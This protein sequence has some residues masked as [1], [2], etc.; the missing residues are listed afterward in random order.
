MLKVDSEKKLR[1]GEI[2]ITP[3][4]LNKEFG[5]KH[6]AHDTAEDPQRKLGPGI[7]SRR[8]NLILM[9]RGSDHRFVFEMAK[10]QELLIGRYDPSSQTSPQV[11]LTDYGAVDKGVSRKHAAIKR[12]SGVLNVVDMGSPN[13]TF[14]NGQRLI[15]DQG[16]V[17]RDGDEIRLGNLVL[18]VHFEKITS[19]LT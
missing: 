10:V 9:V 8:M 14:L 2:Q 3:E 12:K 16:R 19:P 4:E 5:T 18:T 13:G 7:F 17:V 11:D 1:P 15:A 6:V